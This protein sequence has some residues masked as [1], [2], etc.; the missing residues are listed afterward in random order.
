MV[1][2]ADCNFLAA[3]APGS[4][5]TVQLR[6]GARLSFDYCV[7]CCGSDYAP[8]VKAPQSAQVGP[9]GRCCVLGQPAD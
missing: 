6:S 4:A 7:L 2:A 9:P 8:P 1:A 5:G 3:G